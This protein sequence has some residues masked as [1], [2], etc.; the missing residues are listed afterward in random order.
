MRAC[1]SRSVAMMYVPTGM[2][3]SRSCFEIFSSMKALQHSATCFARTEGPP[4][5]RTRTVAPCSMPT[6]MACSW[7]LTPAASAAAASPS[8]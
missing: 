5:V 1:P 8:V 7:I 2:M 3:R 4:A 6:T